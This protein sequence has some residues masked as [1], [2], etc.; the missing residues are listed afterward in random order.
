[1]KKFMGLFTAAVAVLVLAGC[2]QMLGTPKAEDQMAVNIDEKTG[3]LLQKVTDAVASGNR[4]DLDAYL[5]AEDSSGDLRQIVDSSGVVPAMVAPARSAASGAQIV[6]AAPT[7][8]WLELEDGDILLLGPGT[9]AQA[10][11]L[12]LVLTYAYGHAGVVADVGSG[13]PM[14]LSATVT[15]EDGSGLLVG[16][17]YQSYLELSAGASSFARIRPTE[18]LE[19]N[20]SS[21]FTDRYNERNTIY[22]F[23]KL[24]LDPISRWDPI[25]WYCS[26]VAWRV[27][28]DF[29]HKTNVENAGFYFGPRTTWQLQR[30]SLLYQVYSY[31]YWK[32]LGSFWRMFVL[33]P[34]Q[35]LQ[36]VLRELI[37][38]DE[39]R[40][41]FG[42]ADVHAWGPASVDT[43]AGWAALGD[44]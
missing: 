40:G 12:S 11:L 24:N 9:S 19:T 42:A 28:Y 30:S 15:N 20:W 10:E 44:S 26:K 25:S 4:T 2:A 5:A 23:L 13:E 17:R 27:Y 6:P 38:P 34:D 3:A 16:V 1:M 21:Q 7:S 37:T 32:V 41:W 39:V 35:K 43:E 29:A 36:Y 22:A 31:Y 8:E 33:S 18:K 14:V